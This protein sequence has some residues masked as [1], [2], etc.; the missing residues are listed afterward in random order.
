MNYKLLLLLLLIFT[1]FSSE[2]NAQSRISDGEVW[3]FGMGIGFQFR[4]L[5]FDN[6]NS[7][8][9]LELDD[10]AK[11]KFNGYAETYLTRTLTPRSYIEVSLGIGFSVFGNDYFWL[12]DKVNDAWYYSDYLNYGI[13]TPK[14]MFR[15]VPDRTIAD[16]Y[17]I[18]DTSFDP[19]PFISVGCYV[20]KIHNS[21]LNSLTY[22]PYYDYQLE[23]HGEFKYFYGFE[24]AAGLSTEQMKIELS[25][26]QDLSKRYIGNDGNSFHE[27]NIMLSVFYG[28]S[29]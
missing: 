2:V 12:D 10:I 27:S 14:Y 7:L 22:G 5:H 9:G 13:L 20:G 17:K 26:G 28:V 21:E 29:K 19:R 16:D 8:M 25:Y 24:V 23:D 11:N 3:N 6:E 15:F 4:T 18:G 1:T